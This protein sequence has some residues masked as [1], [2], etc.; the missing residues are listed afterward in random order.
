MDTETAYQQLRMRC[1][2]WARED[3]QR[4]INEGYPNLGM[5]AE[6][7]VQSWIVLFEGL[8]N[9]QKRLLSRVLVKKAFRKAISNSEDPFTAQ[10]AAF[11]ELYA[12]SDNA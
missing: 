11:L 5:I 9:E 12:Y 10:D 1:F 7:R 3:F 8:D 2:R 6:R 4:E